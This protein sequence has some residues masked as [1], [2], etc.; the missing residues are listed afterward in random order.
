LK[1]NLASWAQDYELVGASVVLIA[2]G[3]AV[4]EGYLGYARVEDSFKTTQ[5]S[6]TPIS[7]NL[8]TLAVL[9]LVE[10]GEVDLNVD[11]NTYLGWN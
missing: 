9:K 4:V 6:T 11:I 2:K 10:A 5:N 7:K 3:E 1:A 8:S